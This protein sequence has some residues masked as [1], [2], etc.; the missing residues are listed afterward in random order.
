MTFKRHTLPVLS[1]AFSPDGKRLASG[2]RTCTVRVWDSATDC[3][4]W[5]RKATRARV[6]RRRLQPRREASGQCFK[7][8]G[9]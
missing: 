3:K 9:R 4:F 6:E 2:S 7:R 8:P 1:V 5:L